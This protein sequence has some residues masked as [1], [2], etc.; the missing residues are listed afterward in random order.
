M[1]KLYLYKKKVITLASIEQLTAIVAE[2]GYVD[3]MSAFNP[4]ASFGDN[5]ID[6]LDVMTLLLNIEEKM[7]VKFNDEEYNSFVCLNDVLKILNSR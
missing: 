5:G 2:T 6:S 7:G 4:G 1:G 3:D